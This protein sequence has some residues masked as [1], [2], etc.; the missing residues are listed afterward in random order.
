MDFH[1]VRPGHVR[2]K[3]GRD[4]ADP[5]PENV[6]ECRTQ[7]PWFQVSACQEGE[8]HDGCVELTR[9]RL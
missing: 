8:G 4:F 7:C 5:N 9:R 6:S 3:V 2:I 1:K